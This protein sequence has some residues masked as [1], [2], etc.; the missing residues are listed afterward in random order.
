[1]QYYKQKQNVGKM[2]LQQ[3]VIYLFTISTMKCALFWKRTVSKNKTKHL[4]VTL[5]EMPSRSGTIP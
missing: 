5:V 2:D 1:M 3:S 4:F